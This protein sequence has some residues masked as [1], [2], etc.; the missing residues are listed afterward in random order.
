M[1]E[2]RGGAPDDFLFFDEGLPFDFSVLEFEVFTA[3]LS[4]TRGEEDGTKQ[5]KKLIII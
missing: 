4:E 2:L 3:L 5:Q 1:N